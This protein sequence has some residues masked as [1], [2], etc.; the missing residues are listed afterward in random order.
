MIIFFII[1]GLLVAYIADKG[2]TLLTSKYNDPLAFEEKEV[3]VV[4]K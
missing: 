1:I 4:K 2:Y 3:W